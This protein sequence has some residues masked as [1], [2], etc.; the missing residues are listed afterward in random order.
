MFTC[1]LLEKRNH[2]KLVKKAGSLGYMG[3]PLGRFQ[4]RGAARVAIFYIFLQ[5]Y[6]KIAK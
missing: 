4:R 1:F 3:G 5:N 6:A 2:K